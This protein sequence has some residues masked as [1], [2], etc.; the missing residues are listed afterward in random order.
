MAGKTAAEKAAEAAAAKAGETVST[1]EEVRTTDGGE[2]KIAGTSDAAVALAEAAVVTGAAPGVGAA[3]I[4]EEKAGFAGETTRLDET[5]GIERRGHDGDRLGAG[6]RPGDLRTAEGLSFRRLVETAVIARKPG[7]HYIL[8]LSGPT[9]DPEMVAGRKVAKV[10]A[11]Q[12]RRD[13]RTFVSGDPI[14]VDFRAHAELV[15][16]G[17]IVSVP[18]DDLPDA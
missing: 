15:P 12:L 9:V 18:W 8:P 17:A 3:Q 4:V 2:V 11:P 13:G 6:L 7:R 14:E 10:A 5:A 1:V 16:I